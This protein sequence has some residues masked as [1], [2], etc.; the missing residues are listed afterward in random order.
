MRRA[1]HPRPAA[2]GLFKAEESPEMLLQHG[3]GAFSIPNAE[4]IKMKQQ[5]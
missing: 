3:R 4:Q 2:D 1:A 5:I